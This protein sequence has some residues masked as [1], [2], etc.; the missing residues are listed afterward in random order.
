SKTNKHD[1]HD[2]MI[3]DTKYTQLAPHVYHTL[4]EPSVYS[5]DIYS[6]QSEGQKILSSTY[7]DLIYIPLYKHIF[8]WTTLVTAIIAGIV[9]SLYIIVSLIKKIRKKSVHSK[10]FL[11]QHILNLL[12]IVNMLWVS[13]RTLTMVSYASLQPYLFINL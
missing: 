11:I 5:L 12:I 6:E 3:H 1:E 8:E 9:S 7:S 4:E 2:V 13:Y 10:Y